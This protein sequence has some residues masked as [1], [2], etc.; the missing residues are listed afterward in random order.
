MLVRVW[1]R[2]ARYP[3]RID[4]FL[5][6]G[7]KMTAIGEAGN[8][9]FGI[10]VALSAKGD[11]ALIGASGDSGNVG[12]AWVFGRAGSTW[13]QQSRKLTSG[14]IGSTGAFGLRVA[15]SADGNTALVGGPLDNGGIGAAWIFTRSGTTWG[16][17]GRKLTPAREA[18]RSSFGESVALSASGTT[19]LI[20]GPTDANGAGAAWMFVRSGPRWRQVEKLTGSGET[21]PARFGVSAAL[22]S[23]GKTALIGGPLDDNGLGS[24]WV[25]ARSGAGWSQQGKGLKPK[26]YTGQAQFGSSVALSGAGTTALIGAPVDNDDAGA[27]WVFTGSG[28]SWSQQGNKL[29]PKGRPGLVQFGGSVA[30]SSAGGTALV[31]GAGNNGAVG[32]GAAWVFK[33]SGSS[34]AQSGRMLTGR[35]AVG[36]A[37]FGISV[38]LSARGTTAL[39]GGFNDSHGVGAA[40]GYRL[41]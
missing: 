13:R 34:W 14:A 18:G 35:N 5:Q 2:A 11:T 19:A 15:L 37:G 28:S 1:D 16:Q 8:G 9:N 24:V 38:A 22:S 23:S 10:S 17:Q 25:F 40:W 12:A 4:P 26:G 6:Q 32:R 30:L 39:V 20:G 31:G 33:R 41:W 27:A 36:N 3:L 29:T 7:P 21:G